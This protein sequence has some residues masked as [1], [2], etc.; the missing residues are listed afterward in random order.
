MEGCFCF[1]M[2][3]NNNGNGI[4]KR[5][6]NSLKELIFTCSKLAIETLKNGVNDVIPMFLFLTL[7]IFHTFL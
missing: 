1:N 7:S 4:Q 6:Q 3:D 2:C 5:I